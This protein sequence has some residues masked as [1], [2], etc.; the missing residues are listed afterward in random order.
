MKR[1]YNTKWIHSR[2]HV[3]WNW[4]IGLIY[5]GILKLLLAIMFV[6]VPFEC[7]VHLRIPVV[8]KPYCFLSSTFSLSGCLLFRRISKDFFSSSCVGICFMYSETVPPQA[9]QY[10][11]LQALWRIVISSGLFFVFNEA[12]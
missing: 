11:F 7:R 3:S 1:V 5:S 4:S 9:L 6:S 8:F 2:C 12:Q 10:S